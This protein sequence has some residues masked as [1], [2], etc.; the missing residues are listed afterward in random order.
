MFEN[1]K[2]KSKKSDFKSKREDIYSNASKEVRLKKQNPL[3]DLPESSTSTRELFD[4]ID[5]L[6][7]VKDHQRK[8]DSNN[9]SKKL[10]NDDDIISKDPKTAIFERVETHDSS[11]EEEKTIVVNKYDIKTHS[12]KTDDD[13]VKDK[14]EK[15]EEKLVEPNQEIPVLSVSVGKFSNIVRR[16][17]ENYVKY[18][19]NEIKKKTIKEDIPAKSEKRNKIAEKFKINLSPILSK[20]NNFQKKH[21][22]GTQYRNE[23]DNETEPLKIKAKLYET[24]TSLYVSTLILVL[25][26]IASVIFFMIKGANPNLFG[27]GP[28]AP[29]MYCAINLLITCFALLAG[30]K[31]IS[32]GLKAIKSGGNR[33]TGSAIAGFAV[34]IQ[35]ISAFFASDEFYKENYKYYSVFLL[36]IM[37]FSTY[38]KLTANERTRKNYSFLCS[39]GNKYT[40]RNYTDKQTK[41]LILNGVASPKT[42]IVYQCP[43]ENYKNFFGLSCNGYKGMTVI[44]RLAVPTMI[45]AAVISVICG[46]KSGVMAGFNAFTI[47]CCCAAP[48]N[49][50]L[51]SELM[52]KR[53]CNNSLKKKAMLVGYA[54]AR[55][56][57][58]SSSIV[59]TDR[60]LYPKGAPQLIAIKKFGQADIDDPLVNALSVVKA[61]KSPL[62]DVLSGIFKGNRQIPSCDSVIFEDDK[63]LVG[64]IYGERVLVGNA[65]L[66]NAHGIE[67][68]SKDFEGKYIENGCNVTYIATKGT[69]CAMLVVRYRPDSKV[70]HALRTLSEAGICVLVRTSNEAI[71]AEKVASDFGLYQRSIKVLP[72]GLGNIFKELSGEKIENV[73]PYAVTMG[74]FLS[75]AYCFAYSK[76]LISTTRLLTLLQVISSLL[77]IIVA[78][79]ILLNGGILISPLRIIL[80]TLFWTVVSLILPTFTK[81]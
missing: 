24:T 33:D 5:Y 42:N 36:F 59:I 21:I 26:M 19:N 73:K 40:L 78:T 39:A 3:D 47:I 37:L 16:E 20:I 50:V 57:N 66:M 45:F 46:I 70:A 7:K 71:T 11:S 15:A 74:S 61:A 41:P 8:S 81:K 14:K 17:Y 52:T 4:I 22:D 10:D 64:W 2:D 69:L 1:N 48:I 9:N 51:T 28:A 27:T 35:S 32:S 18:D 38:A 34:L 80:Y 63:G 44:N 56:F 31:T 75:M 58:S 55:K 54:S 25:L 29:V 72:S 67:T 77:C 30:R 60:A 23:F 13:K 6:D 62:Y 49:A 12:K 43:S 68:P 53:F 76:R 79:V 65:Q